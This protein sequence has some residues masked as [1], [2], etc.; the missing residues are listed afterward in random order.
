[1][2]AFAKPFRA[3]RP[4][5]DTAADVLAPP[6]DVV[7]RD[8]ACAL[9]AGRPHSFLH[10][11]RPEIDFE[12]GIDPHANAVYD[13]GAANLDRM[14]AT[15]VLERE[16]TPSYYVYRLA[17]GA[18]VQTGIAMA[19]S[20]RAYAANRI[21]RHESTQPDKERDRVRNIESLNAQTGP[22]LTAFRA[23]ARISRLLESGTA[24][25]PLFEVEGP[26]AVR[27]S[28]WRIDAPDAIAS[29]SE[30]L[31]S[32]EALYIAD[33][34]HRSAA[35]AR[36]AEARRGRSRAPTGEESYEYFLTVAFAHD[37][38]A[39]LDY[40]R[41]VADLNGLSTE[42]FLADIGRRVDVAPSSAPVKPSR[43]HTF[44]MYLAGR[45]YRLTSRE[46]PEDPVGRLDVSILHKMLIEPVLGIVDPRNDRR[47]GFV[48][49]SRGH[50][51]LEARVDSGR[52]AVAFALYPTA[53]GEL[54]AVADAGLLMPPK[55][56]WF[57]PKL[58]DG[59][60]SHVLDD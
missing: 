29:F 42:A 5:P 12:P 32:L 58:A 44:G 60:L 4:R 25:A 6:Y 46:R 47:I 53:M 57:E 34:H 17:A 45:W 56:T 54:M 15:G 55:S 2:T 31:A 49:G 59:L 22:V 48:G 40:N 20:I 11:S 8:E 43:R 10:V 27:H 16:R 21:R 19:A 3:L 1:M 13:R 50:E 36:V 23:N 24:S 37:E 14:R 7:D 52:A 41:V 26:G 30:A 33:G 35:A 38:L 39:I 18:H 51:A 28:I 9:A